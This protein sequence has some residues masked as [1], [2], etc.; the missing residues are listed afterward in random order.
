MTKSI[1]ESAKD[2]GMPFLYTLFCSFL[3]P[4]SHQAGQQRD[5]R[6][7]EDQDDA[8]NHVAGDLLSEDQESQ[9]RRQRRFEEE[10]QTVC[11]AEVF[12]MAVK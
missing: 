9:H 11:W 12:S 8:Q 5:E 3:L 10:H 6:A 1:P 7:A 4:Q 2:F